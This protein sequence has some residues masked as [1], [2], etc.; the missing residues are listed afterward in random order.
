[1]AQACIPHLTSGRIYLSFG[2]PLDMPTDEKSLTPQ[3]PDVNNST[4]TTDG[5]L[6]DK[7]EFNYSTNSET[8]INP[9]GV[10]F[11]AIPYTIKQ[12]GHE[13]GHFGGLNSVASNMKA[14]VCKAAGEKPD[15]GQCNKAWAQSEWSSLVIYD[16]NKNLLRIEAPGRFGTRFNNYFANYIN[17][18]SN[19][20]STAQNRS[21]KVDLRELKQGMWSG[22]FEPKS[23]T[24]VFS[25]IDNPS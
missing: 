23:Q 22:S 4:T 19:Y 15:S 20:Y 9:T 24:L 2:N 11:L 1:M 10:D 13:F 3:Q 5:T 8:V 16:S 6:F 21:I 12:A 7:V 25:S 14:I 17:E 18:L